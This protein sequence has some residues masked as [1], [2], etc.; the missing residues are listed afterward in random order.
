MC[1]SN[2]QWESEKTIL[3]DHVWSLLIC[4][5]GNG[6]RR[7]TISCFLVGA[8]ING[9]FFSATFWGSTRTKV[10]TAVGPLLQVS[11]GPHGESSRRSKAPQ[12]PMTVNDNGIYFYLQTTITISNI[13]MTLIE[14]YISRF[15]H[16][17]IFLFNQNRNAMSDFSWTL[18]HFRIDSQTDNILSTLP[19]FQMMFP[20]WSI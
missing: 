3:D 9:W 14:K 13:Q 6:F 15:N 18:K 19:L 4:D 5:I 16:S 2:S 10:A 7:W 1:W 8:K 11:A 12:I 17:I 20:F